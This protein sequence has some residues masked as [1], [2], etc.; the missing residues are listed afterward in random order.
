MRFTIERIRTL[1]LVAGVLLVVALAG[2]LAIGKW[3]N[4]FNRRDIPK[5]LGIDIEQ[6][7]N[8]V[9]YTQAHAGHTLFKIHASKVVQLKNSHAMLHDVQI[10]L[11]GLDGSRV[12]RITGDEF[13]YDQKEGTATATGPVAITLMRPGEKPAIVTDP[14][15]EQAAGMKAHPNVPAHAGAPPSKAAVS[16]PSPAKPDTRGQI[17]VTT[18]GLVFNQQTGIASTTQ[19]VVFTSGQGSGSSVGATYDSQK[20]FLVLDHSVELNSRAAIVG[21][22]GSQPVELHADHAEFEHDEQ[23]CRLRTVTAKT[24]DEAVT[25]THAQIVFRDD[26]SVSELDASDGFT[27][28][29]TSGGHMA[30]PTGTLEFDEGN[31]P[32]FGHLE[33]GVT[34]DSAAGGHVVHGVASVVGIEFNADGGLRHVHLEKGVEVHS[35][36][37]ILSILNGQQVSSEVNRTWRSAVADVEFRRSGKGQKVEP[38]SI[39]GTGSVV[40]TDESRHGSAAP[41]PARMAA[42]EMAGVFGP[43]SVLSSMVGTGHA[44]MEETTATGARE[45]ATGDRLEAHF[46]SGSTAGTGS[47]KTVGSSQANNQASGGA[48]IQSA[49]IEGHVVLVQQPASQTGAKGG[50]QAQTPLKATAGKA[51]YDSAGQWFHLSQ[52]PRVDDG[53]L[54]LSADKLDIAQTS[55]DAFAHGNV[56]ASWANNGTEGAGAT[57]GMQSDFALGGKGPAH[58]I[59][60]E[61]ELH[62]TSGEAIFRGHARLWQEAN[63][64]AA[65]T[66]QIN[67]QRQTL[68][69][70][71]TDA[72]EPVRV[73][74]VAAGTSSANGQ[75][76]TPGKS[77]GASLMR[78]QGGDL[79][80]SGAERKARMQAGALR[81]AVVETGGVESDSNQVELFLTPSVSGTNKGAQSQVDRM[82]ASGHVVLSAQGR[83]GTGEQLAYTS[84]T[85]DYVLTGTATAP[86]RMT[87]PAHGSVTGE[88]LIFHGRDDSVS[89]EGGAHKTSTETTAPR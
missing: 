36:E 7:A 40:V 42:D 44:S 31:Q 26:G 78:V 25:A 80:Y 69:A 58:A 85:G 11:Y 55:G 35:D 84:G 27:V 12:D 71:S 38:A 8:G 3:K 64:V 79:V 30:A 82:T 9:T 76:A 4:P 32:R 47:R 86:P 57:S 43:S 53:G 68:T 45:T 37:K 5:R 39:H 65:P 21:G 60:D 13:E 2:F 29:T 67:R 1:V 59:A 74:M 54:Q 77:E 24:Q 73:V 51:E 6:E 23:V 83:R 52:S 66:I 81:S 70:K 41:V 49:V 62:Q 18:S 63:S 10:E 28:T 19:R 56:K 16:Q 17:S 46:Y 15:V 48:Q 89:I 61:A 33:G 87:D 22:R 50:T 34:M 20:G 75:P 14:L 72:A 88:T